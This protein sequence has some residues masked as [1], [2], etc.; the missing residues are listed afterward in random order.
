MFAETLLGVSLV[1][2]LSPTKLNV[3][4]DKLPQSRWTNHKEHKK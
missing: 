4:M 3:F 2:T 1:W